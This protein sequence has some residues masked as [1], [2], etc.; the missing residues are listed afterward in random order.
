MGGS[1][2]EV[3]VLVIGAG[4]SGAAFTWSLAK[5]GIDV[6][7]LEQG[8]WIDPS[9]YPSTQDDW[10]LHRQTD[11]SPDPNVRGL[12]VDYPVNNEDSPIA[13]LMYNAVGGST[14]HWSAHFPRFHPSDFRVRTLDGVA[15]DWPLSYEQL[16]PYFDLNDTIMGV[17]GITGDPAYPPK[18]P[19]Q[20]PPI[21]L[22]KLGDVMA[23]G[24]DKLGW[25]WWPSD[26]AILSAPYDGRAACN[27]CGPCDIGCTRKAKA[28]TDINYW[29]K[30]IAA[31]AKLETSARVREITLNP[32]GTARGVIFYDQDG[33]V[34]EQRA[35]SV[36]LGC[37][38]I[39]TPRL[40]LN[41]TSAQFPNG[42]ANSSG[43]VGKNLMFHPYSIVGGLFEEDLES[44]AGPNGCSIISQEFYETDLSRGFV[45]GY[46][47]QVAR[48]AGPVT[49]AQ[50]GMTGTQMP[51][52]AKHRET[53]DRQ[54]G[55]NA[56]IAIIGEDLPEPHN[57]VT[58]DPDL[59]DS[60]GIP[61]PKVTYKLSEN[62]AK[63]MDHGIARATEVMEA[64]GA[65]DVQVNPLLRR[66]GWHLLGTARM[67]T[68]AS[69][70]VV[71]SMGRSHDVKN[72]FIIDGSV[73]VTAGAVNPTPTI[74]AVALH[75][76]DQFKQNSRRLLD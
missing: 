36:V 68:H 21:P 24:F 70:S 20:T 23:A 58:I 63:L 46:A 17:S 55:R 61:A 15:D 64:A 4:A 27:N 54:F 67:G 69:N 25:H 44:Y 30:A 41:S 49:T 37:N 48:G 32:D 38:G 35:K 33:N 72:L 43:L 62:S 56:V 5:E 66:G 16:E 53:F 18:S 9:T 13:P 3:D 7:C 59:T 12:D 74:Q 60:D 34:Q 51:W 76:A 14:I 11:F 42:L 71:D 6:L 57:Q 31:G 19:R 8:D 47:F 50:G 52:G 2:Q 26:S 1:R 45:R 22:G 73:F 40:L 39:G 10:E 29:P 28:S 75:I 65:L